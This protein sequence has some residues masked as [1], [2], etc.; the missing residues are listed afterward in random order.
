V[1]A[2][3]ELPAPLHRQQLLWKRYEC[4]VVEL[5]PAVTHAHG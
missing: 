1:P 2:V 4:D 5:T 3:D